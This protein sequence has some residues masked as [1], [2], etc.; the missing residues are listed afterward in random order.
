MTEDGLSFCFETGAA[1]HQGV[2]RDHN[3]DAYATLPDTGI[4]V[5]ADGMGGHEAGDVASRLIVEEIASV[6]VPVSAQDQRARFSERLIRA[7]ERILSHAHQRQL[8][9]VGSTMASLLIYGHELSCV[10]AGDS[11]VYLLRKGILTRLTT[12]HS[13][14]ARM[15]AAGEITEDEARSNPSRN[16]ITRA[17]GIQLTPNPET[18]TGMVEPQDLFLLCSDGLTEHNTDDDLRRILQQ[19]APAQEIADQLIAQTLAR[20]A[21][22]NVTAIVLR[23][24]S[25]QTDDC[26]EE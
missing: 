19:H 7:N 3:E 15:I 4:W 22:D 8:A 25:T 5:V 14:V 18:V 11:R 13:A 24:I 20:G 2:V 12:D 23:C 6:G 10:W 9:T 26:P 1:T 16:V 17:I 21:R